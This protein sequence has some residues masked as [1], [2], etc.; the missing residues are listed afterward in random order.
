MYLAMRVERNI[1]LLAFVINDM[2]VCV[3]EQEDWI[4]ADIFI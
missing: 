4:V 1:R 2:C 3:F